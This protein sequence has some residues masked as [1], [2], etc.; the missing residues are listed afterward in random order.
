MTAKPR[1]PRNTTWKFFEAMLIPTIIKEA[2]QFAITQKPE[3]IPAF[4]DF[5]RGRLTEIARAHTGDTKIQCEIPDRQIRDWLKTLGLEP[6]RQISFPAP[7][8]TQP[9]GG[10]STP[11][12][13]D[14]YGTAGIEKEG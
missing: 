5:F 8:N 3:N 11:P 14:M 4:C 7:S 9:A 1:R 13:D 12:Q 10:G 2:A 6:Q